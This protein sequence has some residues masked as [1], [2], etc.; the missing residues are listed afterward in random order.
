MPYTQAVLIEFQRYA[1]IGPLAA[2]H[3]AVTDL[4]IQGCEIPK[5][6]IIFPNAWKLHHNPEIW[7][8]PWEFIPER[9]LNDDGKL[10]SADH[11]YQKNLYIYG[12]GPRSCPGYKVIIF[13]SSIHTILYL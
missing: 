4:N 11:V 2:P 3:K 12:A 6:C 8:D 10:L 9:F 13:H 7:K 5:G 1:S